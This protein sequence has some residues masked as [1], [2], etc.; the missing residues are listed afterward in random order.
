[1]TPVD[2]PPLTPP[3]PTTPVH[4]AEPAGQQRREPPRRPPRAGQ[5]ARPDGDT[6]DADGHIDT[7]V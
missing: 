2:L 7:H 1:M 4:R 5:P 3:A 6:V